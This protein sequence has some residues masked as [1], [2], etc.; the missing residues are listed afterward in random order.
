MGRIAGLFIFPKMI[1]KNPIA[2]IGLGNYPIVRNNPEFLGFIPKSP[3]GKT[4]AHG[5]G[6]LM[7]LL[8]DGGL[9]IFTLFL[10][11]IYQLFKKLK[12]NGNNEEKFLQI[13]LFFFV[14]GVQIYFLY[15]WVLMGVLMAF[16]THKKDE[17]EIGN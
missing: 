10:I 12:R 9:I 4:D 8:V 1:V 14:F 5:Y 6:G 16:L 15:P 11:I 3:K 2:G 17:K 13:F 7:Q